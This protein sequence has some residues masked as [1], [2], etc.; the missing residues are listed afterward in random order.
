MIQAFKNY[1]VKL[2]VFEGP[3]DLLVYLVQKSELSPKDIPISHITDQYLE[4]IDQVGI[5]N[6]SYAGE[7]LVMAS[8]LMRLKARE[9]LPPED[10][11]ELEEMEY[12]LDKAA[13]L[14]QMM[15]HQKF[16]EAANFYRHLESR[17]VGVHFRGSR[18]KIEK[19]KKEATPL[20]LDLFEP[21]IYE[22]LTAY[23]TAIKNKKRANIHQIE[24]DDV[25]I[26]NQIKKMQQLLRAE[27]KF[28]FESLFKT[29]PRQI[30]I[31]VTFMALLELTKMNDIYLQQHISHGPIW[32]YRKN[33][34]DPIKHLAPKDMDYIETPDF[35]DGLVDFIKGD[36]LE[37][38]DNTEFEVLIRELEES[39]HTAKETRAKY[40]EKKE[41]PTK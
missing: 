23:T 24:I 37:K 29:D 11:N 39:T 36:I 28:L 5:D 40:A 8:R 21:G 15:E 9:L 17:N 38:N 33:T 30:V 34:E 1:E 2:E 12:E 7:F 3:L 26:E 16:K 41:Q 20:P 18:E 22:L 31:V 13:L 14:E 35:Q 25:T 10:K 27:H 6:L 19:K 32:I 4:Y